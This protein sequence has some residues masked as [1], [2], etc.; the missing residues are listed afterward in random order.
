MRKLIISTFIFVQLS[1]FLIWRDDFEEQK[2]F[3]IFA[4][5]QTNN[6]IAQTSMCGL[7]IFSYALGKGSKPRF[8][9]I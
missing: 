1:Y 3:N 2:Y 9:S 7:K 5:L 8:I 4:K 6:K